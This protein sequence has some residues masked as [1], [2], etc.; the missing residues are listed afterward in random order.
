MGLRTTYG[1]DDMR[2]AIKMFNGCNESF[3]QM[4]TAMELLKLYRVYKKCGWDFTPDQWEDWQVDAAIQSG[5]VPDWY[6]D[7]T[8]KGGKSDDCSDSD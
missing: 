1:I 7:E 4:F 5:K 6:P 8:P 2:A 3:N